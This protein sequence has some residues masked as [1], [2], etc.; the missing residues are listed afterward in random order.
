MRRYIRHPSD[1]PISF[2]AGASASDP[3]EG[4]RL[5]DVGLGGLCFSS[6][7]PLQTGAPIRIGIPVNEEAFIAE[8]VIVWCRKDGNRYS[9]GVQ[10]RDRPTQQSI[11]MAH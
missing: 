7:Y 11:R 10:F 6:H 8:G 1:I 5:R 3:P 4:D 2:S 9:V